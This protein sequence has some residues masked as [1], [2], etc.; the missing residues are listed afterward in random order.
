MSAVDARAISL[1]LL[2]RREHSESE[3][4]R[5]LVAR[6]VARDEAHQAVSELSSQDLVND[7][8]FTEEFVRVRSNSGFGPLK[9]AAELRERGVDSSIIDQWINDNDAQWD[10][11][12]RHL[13]QQKYKESPIADYREWARRARFLASRG[14]TSSQ[15]ATAL[16][17]RFS[18]N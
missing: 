5:K 10:Q 16:G 13:A 2:A 14:F 4:I 12:I 8:R 7:E 9:I 17:G 18:S 11:Q 3:L 6:G 15:V 1:R